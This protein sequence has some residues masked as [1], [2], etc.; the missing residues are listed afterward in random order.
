MKRQLG[1]I[2]AV[3]MG[4]TTIPTVAFAEES[5]GRFA[6]Q[7]DIV[8]VHEENGVYR[9]INSQ[10]NMRFSNSNDDEDIIR[11][12]A[13]EDEEIFHVQGDQYVTL[14]DKDVY[15]LV[16]RIDLDST[17]YENNELILD[18]YEISDK[19]RENIN[20]AINEQNEIGNKE[21]EISIFAPSEITTR[22]S[23]TSKTYYYYKDKYFRDTIVKYSNS[24]TPMIEKTGSK[25]KDAASG[26]SSFILSTA[27]MVSKTVSAFSYGMSALDL[28]ESIFGKVTYGSNTDR[29]YT[30]VLYDKLEKQTDMQFGNEWQSTG[31]ISYKITLKRND[32]YQLY[33]SSGESYLC[34]Q[35]L[36]TDYVSENYNNAART[37]LENFP[38][39]VFDN[40]I[41]LKVYSTNIIL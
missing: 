33:E 24:S 12:S 17:N 26:F 8:L 25:T 35:T 29:M 15:L 39:P 31:C 11:V 4:M 38:T 6:K 22:G 1:L 13:T 34:K 10:L 37:V 7:Q 16:D 2:M 41:K 9:P 28:F 18:E 21:F 23:S 30:L 3:V 27:S 14:V 40:A 36:S 5:D 32:T 20:K 19:L